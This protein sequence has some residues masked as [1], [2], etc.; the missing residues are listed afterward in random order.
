MVSKVM[1]LTTQVISRRETFLLS[2]WLHEIVAGEKSRS[3]KS[4][5]FSHER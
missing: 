2:H 5:L 1:D 3:E 4:H